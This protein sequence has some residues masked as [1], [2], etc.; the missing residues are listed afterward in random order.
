MARK[1]V[2][3][4]IDVSKLRLDVALGV[5]AELLQVGNDAGGFTILVEKLRAL[6]PELIVLEASG[7]Y[8]TALV[9][10]LVGAQLPVVVVN[11]RQ[12]RDFARATGQLAKTDA[13]DARI[14][15]LFGERVRPPRRALPDQM[16]RELK[17]LMA[18]R[19]QVVENAGRRAEPSG[20]GAQ[21]AASTAAQPYRLFAQGP[22]AAQPRSRPDAAALG[23]VAG[24]RRPTS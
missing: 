5:E 16:E 6:S 18:R 9:G 24:E 22:G 15:A 21:D 2:W 12:V 14:L 20:P 23:P 19:R 10:E 17:V 1:E 7:G 13:L 8:E 3:V 11:P 4:G